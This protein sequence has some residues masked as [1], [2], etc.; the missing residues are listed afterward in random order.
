MKGLVGL[1]LI[2]TGIVFGLFVGFY[3]CFCGGIVQII[4]GFKADPISTWV[5]AIG[6]LKIVG[7][8]AAGVISAFVLII[9]GL[10]MV[11]SHYLF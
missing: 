9:P 1:L 4:N 2:I 6:I 8:T 10:A 5:I 11:R 7:A 3:I